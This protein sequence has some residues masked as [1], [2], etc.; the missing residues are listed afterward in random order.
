MHSYIIINPTIVKAYTSAVL[1]NWQLTRNKS[2]ILDLYTRT[3]D[4]QRYMECAPMVL[5]L[6]HVIHIGAIMFNTNL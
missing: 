1:Y 2:L 6:A 5:K 3:M 4:T